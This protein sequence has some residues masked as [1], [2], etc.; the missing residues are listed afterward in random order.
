[1]L[2]N[3]GTSTR[4]NGADSFF[5]DRAARQRAARVLDSAMLRRSEKYLNVYAIVADS[6]SLITAAWRTKRLRRA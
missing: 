2:L 3:F 4:C 1:M 5:F 6:G